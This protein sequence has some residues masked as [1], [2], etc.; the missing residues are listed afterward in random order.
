ML[1]RKWLTSDPGVGGGELGPNNGPVC[2]CCFQFGGEALGS[3]S[4]LGVV[5]S[6]LVL[7]L[8]ELA[9]VVHSAFIGTGEGT[10]RIGG[11]RRRGGVIAVQRLEIRIKSEH[12]DWAEEEMLTLSS[13]GSPEGCQKDPRWSI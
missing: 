12:S 8:E 1:Q 2:L 10:L 6:S 4:F 9:D 11:V 13:D 5:L 3:D 7:L